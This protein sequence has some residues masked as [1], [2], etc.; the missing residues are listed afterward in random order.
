[1]ELLTG[2]H[3]LGDGNVPSILSSN[4][5]TNIIQPKLSNPQHNNWIDY[6][7]EQGYDVYIYNYAGYGRSYSCRQQPKGLQQQ[8]KQRQKLS[9]CLFYSYWF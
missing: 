7:L 4:N 6:Y 2:F 1:M 5:N 8:E 9:M 3:F